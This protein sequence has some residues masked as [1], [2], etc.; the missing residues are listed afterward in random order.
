MP[1]ASTEPAAAATDAS[2]SN[3]GG[4]LP[5][6]GDAVA[7]AVEQDRT[8]RRSV[9][10]MA[11]QFGYDLDRAADHADAG[12]TVAQF[13]ELV[14]S[15]T[16]LAPPAG[17]T[18]SS[19]DSNGR[20]MSPRVSVG[21][22]RNL[23][24]LGIAVED[25]ILQRAGVRTY[26]E[27]RHG[28]VVCDPD[29][30]R[31]K[32]RAPHERAEQFASRP[33]VELGRAYLQAAQAGNPNASPVALSG[34]ALGQALLN[35][36]AAGIG[37]HSTSDFSNIL[38]NVVGKSLRAGYVEA[39][40][41]WPAFCREVMVPDFKT[42][43]RT[44]LGEIPALK[45]IGELQ[46]IEEVTFSDS[47]ESYQ[48]SVYGAIF[49][50]SWQT[51]VNDDTDALAR[52]PR[53]LGIAAAR[54][55]DYLGVG[56]LTSNP[57]MSDGK[58][59]FHTDHGNLAS[60]SGNVG[61]PSVELLNKADTAIGTQEGLTDDTDEP[62]VLDLELAG[63]LVPRA[64]KGTALELVQSRIKPGANNG[65]D[66][67]WRQRFEL[68]STARLDMNSTTAWYAFANPEQID[69]IEMAFLDGMKQPMVTVEDGFNTLSRR[70]RVVQAVEAKA[71]D[72]RGLYK[73]PGA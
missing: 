67:I 69:T 54:K 53:M 68:A 55:V 15:S 43:S 7:Q 58:A 13:G 62:V 44:Q 41:V 38:S 6:A 65:T 66:N 59:L 48:L 60:G 63:L 70:W 36:R 72:W 11:R 52:L 34:S 26:E 24:T 5:D 17:L 32:R 20:S 42:V 40:A 16:H 51:L 31:P 22:D 46:E 33:L 3:Q 37:S 1:K 49:G 57:T 14:K 45:E 18:V 29:T 28:N 23:D 8:R 9:M 21:S 35:P 30:G 39:P 64:L 61:A 50:V 25:A 71:I 2:T 12:M 10:D 19:S 73:N 56:V 47:K 27:D 4:A